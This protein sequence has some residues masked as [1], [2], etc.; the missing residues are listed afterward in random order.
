[1]SHALPIP[2]WAVALALAAIAPLFVRALEAA[3]DAR[4]RARTL[5]AIARAR[6]LARHGGAQQTE[7]QTKSVTDLRNSGRDV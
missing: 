5:E 7:T 2:M 1:M 6:A 3:V 4:L